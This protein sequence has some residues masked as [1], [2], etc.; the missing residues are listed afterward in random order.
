MIICL[1]L[2]YK[3]LV[4]NE[5]IRYIFKP[6]YQHVNNPKRMCLVEDEIRFI[7]NYV[8]ANDGSNGLFCDRFNLFC[9]LNWLKD[10][11]GGLV[12]GSN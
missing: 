5:K 9:L 3:I 12:G 6:N 10:W 11:V 2:A 4:N 7:Y 1:A 8:T